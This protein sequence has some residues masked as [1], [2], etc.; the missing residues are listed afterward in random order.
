M[1]ITRKR[2]DAI[3]ERIQ[4]LESEQ[5][6]YTE[7]VTNALLDAATG[8]A[9]SGYVAGLEIAAGQLS[10]AFASA[11]VEGPGSER[12]TATMM[13]SIGRRLVE[14]GEVPRSVMAT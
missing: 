5:R 2:F 7:I 4:T 10:R 8:K 3:Q 12:F 6:G 14:A 13:A 1:F 11:R 9:S